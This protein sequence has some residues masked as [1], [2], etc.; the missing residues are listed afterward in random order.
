VK[1]PRVEIAVD[2]IPTPAWRI[3]VLCSARGVREVRLGDAAAPSARDG[4][5]RGV[6]Y[7]KRPRWTDPPRRALE[8]YLASR[9][10]LDD[11]A[12]DVEAGTEFQRRV[13]DAAR[14]IP[15][16]QVRSYAEVARMA[17]TPAAMRAVGNALGMNPVAIV[18]PC[19]RVVHADA[20]LGGF[21]AGLRWKRFLLEHERGQQLE[22]G[23]PVP[24]RRRRA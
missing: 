11:V 21:S 14:R 20:G 22:L 15:L 12:L 9:A 4:R 19:H 24:K 10:S 1:A 16:G 13:W 18:V 23:M 8:R 7:V 2:S 6:A 5:A 17:G 3:W